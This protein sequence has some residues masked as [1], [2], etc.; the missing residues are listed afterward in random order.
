MT[1][2]PTTSPLARR[3]FFALLYFSEGAP[4]GYVWWAMP[5]RLRAGGMPVEEVAAITAMLTFPWALKFL[6]AP[7]I[8]RLRGPRFGYRAWITLA[9]LAMGLTLLPLGLLP[10]DDLLGVVMWLLVAHAIAAATQDVGIDALAIA[11]VPQH[12]RGSVTG[13]MQ[14]GMLVA[15]ALFGGV[16]LSA[17]KWIGPQAVVLILIGCIWFTLCVVWLFPAARV[18]PQRQ[19]VGAPFASV[20]ARVLSRRSTW[21]ALAIAL[22]AGAGFEAVGLLMGPFLL[23]RGATQEDVGL[24]RTLSVIPMIAGALAGGWAADR[25]GHKRLLA[26]SVAMIAICIAALSLADAPGGVRGFNLAMFGMPLYFCIGSLT[27]SSYAMFMDVSDPELGGTQFSAF[28]GA[29][30]LCEVWAV[31]L[32]GNIAGRSGYGLA[33]AAAAAIS[34]V[35]L[36]FLPLMGP[37]RRP[38]AGGGE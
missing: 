12:E 7:M 5:T 36:A 18:S 20:L 26:L 10:V 30:N 21:L 13:W 35:S 17:E 19:R 25:T 23:D 3:G 8:D 15:R 29:T 28:M 32:A 16:A 4:I 22:T 6:W 38:A 37:V 24:F 14:A 34:M 9:Q 27:A 11:T 1:A 33:F 2:T 31:A